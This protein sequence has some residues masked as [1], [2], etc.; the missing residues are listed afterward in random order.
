MIALI[1]A[2]LIVL[3]LTVQFWLGELNRRHVCAHADAVPAAFKATMDET[4]YARSVQY[5][6]AKSRLG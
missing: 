3:K 5:T 4:T 2:G 6:L 1:I